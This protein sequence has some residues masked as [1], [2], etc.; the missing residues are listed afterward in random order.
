MIDLFQFPLGRAMSYLT[1][2]LVAPTVFSDDAE[3]PRILHLVNTDKG[4][5]GGLCLDMES[6]AVALH[7]AGYEFGN[8][9][10][11]AGA[12]VEIST[13]NAAIPLAF[14]EKI[15]GAAVRQS[16]ERAPRILRMGLNLTPILG[17]QRFQNLID[18]AVRGAIRIITVQTSFDQATSQPRP[19]IGKSFSALVIMKAL[20]KTPDNIIFPTT[21][22]RLTNDARQAAQYI[23]DTVQPHGPALP[24]LSGHTS[25]DAD[26]IGTLVTPVINAM[27]KAAGNGVL[28]LVIDDLDRNPVLNESTA[29]TFLNALYAAAVRQKQLRIVLI[30]PTGVLPGTN[31]LPC[32]IDT[33]EEHIKD[34]DLVA[35]LTGEFGARMPILPQL[36]N[37][38]AEIARSVAAE[39]ANDPLKGQTGALAQVL[40]S[41]WIPKMQQLR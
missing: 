28:W 4:S 40:Q 41:H 19:K 15:A 8:V 23:V 24:D 36:A 34:A 11:A 30:G 25:L 31:G 9:Q 39:I 21:S 18:D 17:R 2:E 20:L 29:S 16:I 1:G 6:N 12:N 5:S 35:W 37:L 22:A 38:M 13:M 33:V 7:Q 26:A 27:C 14:I 32:G 3:P 10:N